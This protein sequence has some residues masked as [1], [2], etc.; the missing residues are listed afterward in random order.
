M[1]AWP[2]L[3]RWHGLWPRA[4][5]DALDAMV[6]DDDHFDKTDTLWLCQQFA[7]EKW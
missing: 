1:D 4:P 2:C 7:I 3:R 5:L 6:K